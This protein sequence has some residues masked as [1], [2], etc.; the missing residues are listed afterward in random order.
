MTAIGT[1]KASATTTTSCFQFLIGETWGVG[2]CMV[3]LIREGASS[4]RGTLRWPRTENGVPGRSPEQNGALYAGRAKAANLNWT[5]VRRTRKIVGDAPVAQLDRVLV[6]EA[7]GHRFDSCR[8]RHSPKE[9]PCI[10]IQADRER[11]GLTSAWRVFVALIAAVG[12]AG[13][14]VAQAPAPDAGAAP[15]MSAEDLDS[16]VGRIALYPDD[17]VAIILPASTSPLQIVQADRF[18]DKR[19]SDPKLPID[20]KW[21]DSVKALVNYP[22]VVKMM[23]GDLDWTSALGEA[24]VADQGDVLEAIQAFRRRAQ[25]AGNLK[26]RPRSRSSKSRRK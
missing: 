4:V 26:S 1:T 12:F 21:D 25:A 9:L 2:P 11:C 16:L 20:E 15:Q 13:H 7:K 23:S 8:A 19:K 10:S 24:V 22:D 18:L 3:F 17:L 6:S 14:G 5:L